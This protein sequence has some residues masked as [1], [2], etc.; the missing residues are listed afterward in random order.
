MF[1]VLISLASLFVLATTTS[2]SPQKNIPRTSAMSFANSTVNVKWAANDTAI[3]FT[4]HASIDEGW[5][6]LGWMKGPRN[7]ISRPKKL[8]QTRADVLVFLQSKVLVS[9]V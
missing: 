3:T 1:V 6:L 9:S 4:I 5:F 7:A 2:L 8:E